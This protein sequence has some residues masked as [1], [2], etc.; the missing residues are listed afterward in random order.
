MNVVEEPPPTAAPPG[1]RLPR[2]RLGDTGGVAIA[3][4]V[5]LLVASV[6]M[7]SFPT[8]DNLMNI[9]GSNSVVLALA[10][11]VTFVII[12]GGIDLSFVGVTA[13][14]GMVLGL[15]LGAGLPLVVCLA[16]GLAGG[17]LLGLVNGLLIARAGISFLVVTLGMS[18][19][20]TS[21]A[22]V[23]NDGATVNVF[24]EPAFEPLRTF[25]TDDV[26][27]VPILLL[28]DVLLVLLAAGV[29]N[30]TRF[31]RAL[32]AVGSNAEAARL[33]GVD[34]RRTTVWVYV[35]AGLTAGVAAAIQ[36]GRL[37]GA[38]PQ[39]DPSLLN[40]V[41]A[42][43][44][45]GGAS[46]TGGKGGVAGTVLGVLFLGVVQ[47]TMTLTDVSSFWRQ[48]VNGALLILAV[49]IGVAR[50]SAGPRRRRRKAPLGPTRSQARP[51]EVVGV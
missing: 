47:N 21:L 40:G 46:F 6:T 13:T 23:L 34:V 24:E 44:L 2:L 51:E 26:G 36:V 50:S 25:A 41:L 27:P 5:L 33:N 7:P 15:L 37:T 18:S 14:S 16:A 38:S 8:W 49:G 45:I 12:A 9:V 1:R 28:F 11:G 10:I 22:L 32:Y 19:I 3:L 42:A 35:L 43:V 39:T 31:G 29:L 20:A 30:Y 17:V 4:A 48:A